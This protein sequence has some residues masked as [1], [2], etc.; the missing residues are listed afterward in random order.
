VTTHQGKPLRMWHATPMAMS[1]S[2]RPGRVATIDG[3]GIWV[4]TGDGYLVL[5]EVQPASGRRMAAVAYARGHALRSEDVLGT[6]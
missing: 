4:E 6:C 3:L 1:G 2:G 5:L